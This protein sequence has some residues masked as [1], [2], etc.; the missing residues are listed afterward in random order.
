MNTASD[1]SDQKLSGDHHKQALTLR[2][3]SFGYKLGKPPSTNALFDVRFLKNP[4]WVE[5]LRPMTGRDQPVQEYVMNQEAAKVFLGS[6]VDMLE[7]LVPQLQESHLSEFSIAF[8][9]TG[10]QHRSTTMV[11]LLAREL[12]QRMPELTVERIHREL[13]KD[14]AGKHNSHEDG[15]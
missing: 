1:K 10:G 5:H 6:L 8:G 2:I 3:M 13:D 15:Q 12:A 9:C 7:R 11:E 14:L 4:Y